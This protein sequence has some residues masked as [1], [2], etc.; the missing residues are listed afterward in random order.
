M[1]GQGTEIVLP[2]RVDLQEKLRK[3][4]LDNDFFPDKPEG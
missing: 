2:K 3:G 1:S 4:A